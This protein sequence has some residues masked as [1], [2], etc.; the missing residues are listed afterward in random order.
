M[1][2]FKTTLAAAA[3]VLVVVSAR[4]QTQPAGFSASEYPSIQAALDARPGQ[5]IYVP[6]GDWQISEKIRIR[7]DRSGLFGPGRIVQTNPNAPIVEIENAVGVRLRDLTL[8]RP[9]GKT[10]TRCEALIAMRCRDLVIDGLQILDNQTVASAI[11]LRDCSNCQIRGCLIE[12]YMRLSVD[13][14]TASPDWGYAFLCIDGTGIGVK[15]SRGVLIQANRVVERRFLPTPE[16]QKK[17][18]LGRVIKRNPQKG[19]IISEKAWQADYVDNWHQG[20]AIFASSP[21]E[22]EMVQILG[23]YIENAAQGIDLHCDRAIVS[24]NIV[25][26]AHI[27]M[28]AMHGSA[29]VLILGNQFIRNDLWSIGLMPGAA[30]HVAMPAAEGKPAKTANRDGGS[31]IA[32]NIISDFGYGH[33]RWLWSNAAACCPIRLETGQT[34]ENPPLTDVIVQGNIIYVTGRDGVLVDGEVKVEPPRYKYAVLIS[35]GPRGPKNVRFSNNIFHPGTAGV[36]NVEI[37]E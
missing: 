23:N 29:H 14:R 6:P 2:F 13:D 1:I 33:S 5:M 17:H 32:N 19:R 25:N 21:E 20:S 37:E 35:P 24:Q 10:E 22:T 3:L 36:S 30:S 8:T 12:N 7:R 15:T 28:K 9:E 26:T 27:G 34:P 16:M 4:A 11:A 31:I 18:D